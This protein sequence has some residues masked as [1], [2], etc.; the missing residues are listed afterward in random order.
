MHVGFQV[1]NRPNLETKRLCIVFCAQWK[2]CG[3]IRQLPN[4]STKNPKPWAW[5]SFIFTWGFFRN[6][7]NLSVV[8]YC[9]NTGPLKQTAGFSLLH[10]TL[11]YN[12]DE[13][14]SMLNTVGRDRSDTFSSDATQSTGSKAVLRHRLNQ[15]LSCVDGLDT[16]MELHEKVSKT[17]D[18]AFFVCGTRANRQRKKRFRWRTN[19]WLFHR[20]EWDRKDHL[21]FRAGTFFISL[22]HFLFLLIWNPLTLLGVLSYLFPV[23]RLHRIF[24]CWTD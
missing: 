21:C 23:E 17:L 20:V 18:N 7:P 16:E 1:F 13:I 11:W 2:T 4:S 9:F 12:M 10:F 19:C 6:S 5:I 14:R 3:Q 24:K 22:F 8:A 15:L